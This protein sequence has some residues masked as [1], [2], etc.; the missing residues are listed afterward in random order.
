MRVYVLPNNNITTV[1]ARYAV[2]I[3]P[4]NLLPLHSTKKKN[5]NIAGTDCAPLDPKCVNS[6][7][8][9]LKLAMCRNSHVLINNKSVINS[10]KSVRAV[11]IYS[12]CKNS[13]T[14]AVRYYLS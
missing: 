4:R 8:K 9:S 14:A 6:K 3:L 11:S 2:M 13:C 10:K 5:N 1:R 12:S 7:K